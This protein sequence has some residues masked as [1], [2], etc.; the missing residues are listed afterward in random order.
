[1][2]RPPRDPRDPILTVPLIM[3]TGLVTLITT[4]GAL[5]LFHWEQ[6]AAGDSLAE[7]RT[8]VV[9]TIVMVETFYLFNCRSLTRSVFSIGVFSNPW[10][11]WGAAAMVAAQVLFTYAPFMNRLFHTA[12]IRAESWLHIF[13]VAAVA[14]GVVG[15]EK[16][17]RFRVARAA[18]G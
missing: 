10:A 9:N 15:L 6:Q 13:G 3:R 8:I 4:V 1:M 2:Q 12:P 5:F 16:W 14:Y 17:I 7:A 11:L 18:G